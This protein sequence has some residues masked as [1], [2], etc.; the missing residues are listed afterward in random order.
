MKELRNTKQKEI[1]LHTLQNMAGHYTAEEVYQ[2]V[3]KD[4]PKISKATV[5]RDLNYLASVKHALKIQCSDGADYF[6][7]Q[8]FLHHHGKCT[9]CNKVFDIPFD[10]K[11]IDINRLSGDFK[12]TGYSLMFYGLC[13][14]CREGV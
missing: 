4:Y 5:Y 1:I 14:S 11:N 13:S 10:E 6:D 2:Q 9:K 7:Y 12:V 8:T 3:H